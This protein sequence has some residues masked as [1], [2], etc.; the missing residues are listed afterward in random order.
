MTTT[1]TTPTIP[2]APGSAGRHLPGLSAAATVA[3]KTFQQAQMLLGQTVDLNGI[4]AVSG[5]PGCGKTFAV[6]HFV[7]THPSMHGRAWHWLDMPP[8]PTTKEVTVRLLDALG[9]RRPRGATEYELTELLDPA[10][11]RLNS[12]VVIDEAQNLKTDGLQQLRYLHDRGQSRSW[13]LLLVGSTVKESLNGAAELDSRVSRWLTFKPLTDP[14]QLLR[15]LHGWHPVLAATP[16]DLLLRV[17]E[18]YARGN[19]RLWAQFLQTLL[20]LLGRRPA[21]TAVDNVLV[22]AALAAVSPSTIRAR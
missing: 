14:D 3:T 11:V 16:A 20:F 13:A 7:R 9:E 19:F 10:L 4:A 21:G 12:V 22:G 2:P 6:D 1:S 15:T 5:K 18:V 8:K 17:D